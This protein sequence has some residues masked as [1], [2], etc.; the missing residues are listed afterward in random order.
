MPGVRSVGGADG[1]CLRKAEGRVDREVQGIDAVATVQ[2]CQTVVVDAGGVEA[3]SVPAVRSVGRT[4][5][6]RLVEAVGRIDQQRVFQDT[7]AAVDRLQV[8]GVGLRRV[9][10]VSA[11]SERQGALAHRHGVIG[12]V[13]GVHDGVDDV[14]VVAARGVGHRVTVLAGGGDGLSAPS[15]RHALAQFDDRFVEDLRLVHGQVQGIDAVAAVEGRQTVMVDAGGR[16]VLSVPAEGQVVAADTGRLAEAI[17]RIHGQSQRIDAVAAAG[18]RQTVGIDTAFRECLSVP[19]V[20][21]VGGADGRRLRKAEGRVHGQVQSI[22]AVATVQGCQT[23]VVDAAFRKALAV[24]RIRCLIIANSQILCVIVSGIDHQD[25]TIDTVAEGYSLVV[26]V[27][28]A[29]S[30]QRA[31]APL[32][33]QHVVTDGDRVGK[34][35]GRMN[36]HVDFV[37]VVASLGIRNGVVVEAAF[38]DGAFAP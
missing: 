2:G 4:D 35:I 25:K 31:V 8:Q 21:S 10:R 14:D 29:G 16:E 24:P 22:D 5:R 1:H 15:L 38:R 3:L 27:I 32:I 23:V 6:H 20:R 37:D 36:G 18:R 7:V 12:V 28:G 11:P 13:G 17:G 19:G 33:R 9:E 34:Q 30:G 26:C